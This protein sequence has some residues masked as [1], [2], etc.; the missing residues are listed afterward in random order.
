MTVTAEHEYESREFS[1]VA[2]NLWIGE[3]GATGFMSG[4]Q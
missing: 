2:E 3:Q 1:L 4:N